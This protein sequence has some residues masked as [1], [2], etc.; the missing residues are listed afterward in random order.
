MSKEEMLEYI[1]DIL[2]QM[3]YLQIEMVYGLILGLRG[4][5]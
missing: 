5:T 2:P 3:E 4:E 1:A